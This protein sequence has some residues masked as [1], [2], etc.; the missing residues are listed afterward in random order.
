MRQKVLQVRIRATRS[1]PG[2]IRPNSAVSHH[3]HN[4]QRASHPRA[5]PS[6]SDRCDHLHNSPPPGHRHSHQQRG[7]PSNSNRRGLPRS[8]RAGEESDAPV[9]TP[10]V[11]NRARLERAIP[12]RLR[13]RRA[14]K[15]L[16]LW[17]LLIEEGPGATGHSDRPTGI[18]RPS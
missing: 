7:R 1:H 6:N 15:S 2:S 12:R 16:A 4:P 14:G 8:L 11:T 18:A 10:V 9:T 3:K 17:R 13:H 5:R